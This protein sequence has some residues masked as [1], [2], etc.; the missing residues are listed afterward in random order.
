MVS[1]FD[2]RT[3]LN[4]AAATALVQNQWEAEGRPPLLKLSEYCRERG[5]RCL[6]TLGVPPDAWFVSL[7][8]RDTGQSASDHL[9]GIR[10]ADIT[11][12]EAAIRAIVARGGWVIRMGDP[13]MKP[14][15]AMPQVIDYAQ[16]KHRSDWMDVFLCAAC[17]FFIGTQSG[18]GHVPTT[19]GVP[20]VI[21][22]WMSHLTPPWGGQNLY[23]T[24]RFWSE[25]AN[26]Y[27]T[28]AEIIQSGL[29]FA[30]LSLCFTRQGV[31]VEDNSPEDIK[32]VVEEMLD[33][34]DGSAFC[35]E[36]DKS[37][38]EEFNRLAKAQG[39]VVSSPIGRTFLQK[40]A[41][42]LLA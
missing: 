33:R 6:Q 17:R 23:I 27:L 21:T 40:Y 36:A 19:F 22:N 16:S 30:Q 41:T 12:Y 39:V 20:A 32:D 26:R 1:L 11:T 35:H 38:A 9:H 4:L 29:G 10:N 25:K 37:L 14:M 28:F 3:H 7:H 42:E 31:R 15:Q 2:G 18:L 13:L 24:K 8:V 5:L 34:F